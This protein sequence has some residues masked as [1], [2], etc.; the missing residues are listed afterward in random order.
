MTRVIGIDLGTTNSCVAVI[1][2]GRPVV[3]PDSEGRRTT[4]SIFAYSST[5][6]PLVGYAAREQAE[7]N[8]LNTIFAVKRLIGRKY[9]AEE[10][11]RAAEKLPYKIV[12]APNGDAWVLVDNQPLSPEEISSRILTRMKEVAEGYLGEKV[13]HAVITVPAHFNDAER[14]A[15]KDAG[16]IAGLEVMRIINEPT[17]AAL[18]YG[19]DLFDKSGAEANAARDRVIAVFDLGGGTFDITILA[20]KSGNFEVLA[21]GGD[22]YLGGEDFDLAIVRYLVA[23]FKKQSGVDLSSDRAVLQRL[24]EAAVIAKHDLSVRHT[25]HVS[26]PFVC[27]GTGGQP[28]HLEIELD[29][30]ALEKIVAPILEKLKVPC[31]VALNDAGLK[32]DGVDDVILVGGMTRMPAIK[33][34]CF[35]VFGKEPIDTVDPDEAVALGAAIQAGLL[36]GMVKGV[37][38]FDVISLSLGLETQGGMMATLLPRNTKIPASVTETF[39]TSA[40]NQRQVSIHVLQGESE[41]APENKTLGRFEL[42]GIDPAPRGVPEI[43]VTFAVDV[44]GIVHVSAKDLKT[45]EAKQIEIFA[46]SGLS[47]LE[48]DSLIKE[49]R[50]H[51]LETERRDSL[52]EAR[53]ELKG[54]IFST[55]YQLDTEGKHIRGDVRTE[56]ESVLEVARM[57]LRSAN[58]AAQLRRQVVEVTN[59]REKLKR[60]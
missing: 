51:L 40:P 10:I 1:E 60:S 53:Q 5:Q 41:F 12:P 36:Q 57:E 7:T 22:T 27:R 26:L 31:V 37:S 29:R 32:P 13:Y 54:L 58:D 15:T 50:Q 47:D 33:R 20:L 2:N 8:R 18:A 21:T 39:T 19:L 38:L 25:T 43:A 34:V 48:I 30:G 55:Q 23:E 28:Q 45:G 17:A 11:Q 6:E 35:R 14:Q 24:K 16:K 4:P 9:E 42:T 56:Y 3:I 46:S 59:L 44:E 52:D 49:N